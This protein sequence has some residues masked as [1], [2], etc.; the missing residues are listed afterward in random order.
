MDQNDDN[1]SYTMADAVFT[2]CFLNMC[3]RNCNVVGMAAFAPIVNTRGCI[4]TYNEGIVLR[5]TYHVFDLYVNY[6]GD[7]VLDSWTEDSPVKSLESVS[8]QKT[9]VELLD[10]TATAFSNK[11]GMAIA[12]VNKDGSEE[13]SFRLDFE[14]SGPVTIHY[15]SGDT[16]EAYNDI[17]HDAVQIEKKSL[18]MFQPGMEVSL[19]PHSVNIIW[20]GVEEA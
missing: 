2:A 17:G 16:T 13:R 20:I 11:K 5:S 10:V 15:I 3:N 1:S 14:A 12:A 7:V 4:F 18:G 19:C 8:K 6:L 9:Q